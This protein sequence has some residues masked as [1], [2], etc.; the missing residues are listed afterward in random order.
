MSVEKLWWLNGGFTRF[1][2][3]NGVVQILERMRG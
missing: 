2:V 1:L 3:V